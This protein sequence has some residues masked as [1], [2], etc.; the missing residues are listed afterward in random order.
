MENEVARVLWGDP[1]EAW[2]GRAEKALTKPIPA[3]QAFG[4]ESVEAFAYWLTCPK[5]DAEFKAALAGRAE[6]LGAA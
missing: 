4:F 1:M 6:S 5:S 2:Y 3:W